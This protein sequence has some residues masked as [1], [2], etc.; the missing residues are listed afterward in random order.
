MNHEPRIG[1]SEPSGSGSS[2]P[3]RHSEVRDRMGGNVRP[4]VTTAVTATIVGAVGGG[5]VAT[6]MD[7]NLHMYMRFVGF[8]VIVAIA[9][10]GAW[11]YQTY[12]RP[13]GPHVEE[14]KADPTP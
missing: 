5:V 9:T 1:G 13:E 6:A 12:M 7:R 2:R 8:L 3:H 11:I 4:V 10:V 14:T